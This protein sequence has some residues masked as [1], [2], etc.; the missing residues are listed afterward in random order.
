MRCPKTRCY[1][2][3]RQKFSIL[4]ICA[5]QIYTI[6]YDKGK[7]GF[8]NKIDQNVKITNKYLMTFICAIFKTHIFKKIIHMALYTYTCTY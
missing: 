3:F 1:I 6:C 2:I 8:K 5:F 4:Q 7:F